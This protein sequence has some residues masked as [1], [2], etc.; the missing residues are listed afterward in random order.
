MR[1]GV[2]ALALTAACP[3]AWSQDE[4]AEEPA[5]EF[6][7]N[8]GTAGSANGNDRRFYFSPMASWTLA[9]DDRLTDDAPGA[10]VSLGRKMTA[11]LNLEL[12]GFAGSMGREDE[13]LTG[14]SV[15]LTGFGAAAML[16]PSATFT[17]L[18]AILALHR[19]RARGH[20]TT[21]DQAGFDY[22]ST[23]FDSG[24]GWLFDLRDRLGF[25]SML[26]AEVRY[27]MDSHHEGAA[28]A[29]GKDEFYE[30][31]ITLGLLVPLGRLP[32]EPA[33]PGEDVPVEAQ[34]EA[35]PADAGSEAQPGCHEPGPGEAIS[36]EGCATGEAV[37]LRGVN[38]ET[39]SSRLTADA[40]VI[41]NQVADSLAAAPH[42]SVEIGG[43]TDAQGSDSFT[44]KLSERR[45]Q[46]VRDYLASRGIDAVRLAAKGYGETQPVDSNETVDGRELN[47]R[48][49]MKVLEG[50][51]E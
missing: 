40:K 46:A 44:L 13:T 39:G 12:T 21:P 32:G 25:E 15:E 18:Y 19:G 17:Q 45:A 31:V 1:W 27:R 34:D 9:D 10:A 48:V 28:G 2:L 35:P 6:S 20:P 50:G 29:G 43:H 51:G 36:L 5:D 7:G 23:V 8:D 3:A 42:I 11:G 16:F 24:I 38:F 22:T 4:P 30:P 49:E 14:A 41:L 47:R 33:P 37:V 26:R